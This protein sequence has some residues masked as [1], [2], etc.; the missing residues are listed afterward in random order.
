MPSNAK[1]GL[2]RKRGGWKD[3]RH[4]YTASCATGANGCTAAKDNDRV[5][6]QSK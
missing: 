5:H 6:I 3:T 1:H 4:V 2:F